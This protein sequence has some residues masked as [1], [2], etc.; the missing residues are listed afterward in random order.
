MRSFEIIWYHIWYH[1]PKEGNLIILG[2]FAIQAVESTGTTSQLG[3][4]W[5]PQGGCSVDVGNQ[6]T[7]CGCSQYGYPG[8]PGWFS[9]WWLTVK[10]SWYRP[11]SQN[12]VIGDS[13]WSLPYQSSEMEASQLPLASVVSLLASV[14]ASN[15]RRLQVILDV[16]VDLE[17][18]IMNMVGWFQIRSCATKS[19]ALKLRPFADRKKHV[20]LSQL[21]WVFQNATASLEPVDLERV[22]LASTS[23]LRSSVSTKRSAQQTAPAQGRT[24]GFVDHGSGHRKIHSLL[25]SYPISGHSQPNMILSENG[26]YPKNGDFG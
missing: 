22:F 3:L 21:F 4:C 17:H 16:C 11:L 12:Q 2:I 13:D 10:G 18:D 25:E 9:Q 24:C 19:K 20:Q 15:F 5:A 26:G 14:R 7:T 8:L 6:L 23:T 1:L